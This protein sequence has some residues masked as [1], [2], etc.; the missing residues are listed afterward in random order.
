MNIRIYGVKGLAAW[1]L[2]IKV[3]SFLA[4]TVTVVIPGISGLVP[5]WRAFRQ[6]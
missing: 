5:G 6:I 3:H 1:S 4:Y 2:I